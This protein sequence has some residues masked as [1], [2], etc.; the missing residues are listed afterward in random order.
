MKKS[1]LTRWVSVLLTLVLIFSMVPPVVTVSAAQCA[2]EETS[3]EVSTNYNGTHS[4]RVVCDQCGETVQEDATQVLVDLDFKALAKEAAKQSWWNDLPYVLTAN[5][6]ETR[7]LGAFRNQTVSDAELAAYNAMQAYLAENEGWT[8]QMPEW[9]KNDKVGKRA[10]LCADDGIAWGLAMHSYIINGSDSSA[11]R[12]SID[13]P[14]T[15]F[16]DLT[17]NISRQDNA[18]SDNPGDTNIFPGGASIDVYANDELLLDNSEVAKGTGMVEHTIERV[19]LEQGK[20]TLRIELVSN[21]A[22]ISGFGSRTNLNLKSMQNI[23]LQV[24]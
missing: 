19:Y 8:F 6:Y 7:R 1:L 23:V 4:T 5:G 10:Y 9:D 17:L 21:Y 20:N 18:S 13:V 2:H 15:G 12:W 11:F 3:C 22:N 24:D 16:Y 14:E